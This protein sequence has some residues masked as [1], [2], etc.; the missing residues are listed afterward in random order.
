MVLFDNTEHAV[1]WAVEALPPNGGDS[2][3]TGQDENT[4][5]QGDL[6]TSLLDQK[7]DRVDTSRGKVAENRVT[8]E[9]M[10]DVPANLVE[11]KWTM[12]SITT[13]LVKKMDI[14]IA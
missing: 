4:I 2:C 11:V 12:E 7:S 10:I 8:P 3:P 5:E 13:Q 14:Q 1:Q 6:L 9:P